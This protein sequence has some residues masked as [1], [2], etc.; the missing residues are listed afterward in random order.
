MAVWLFIPGLETPFVFDDWQ[1]LVHSEWI[2]GQVSW[3]N[4]YRPLRNLSYAF[5]LLFGEMAPFTFHV[6][7]L[8]YHTLN[9]VLLAGVTRL[10]LKPGSGSG[11]MA[12]AG[13]CIFFALHPVQIES[14]VYISGR[15]D[16]LFAFFYLGGM[17][18]FLTAYRSRRFGLA[19]GGLLVFTFLSSMSKEAGITLP[20][21]AW[22][23]KAFAGDGPVSPDRHPP[24]FKWKFRGVTVAALAAFLLLA[25]YTV[26][27]AWP[28][29]NSKLMGNDLLLH[30]ENCSVFLFR[31]IYMALWPAGL[32]VDHSEHSFDIIVQ[33]WDPLGVSALLGVTLASL[34]A[35]GTR[36]G[37]LKGRLS[38]N[39]GFMLA[40]KGWLW[41]II[42]ILPMSNLIPH[43]ERFAVHY[44]Y[45]PLPGI[46]MMIWGLLQGVLG[47]VGNG[48][49][50]K[51][52][53]PGQ[54]LGGFLILVITISL[55]IKTRGEMKWWQDEI[56][57]WN[58][59][60]DINPRCARALTN[61][62]MTLLKYNRQAEASDVFNRALE[63]RSSPYTHIGLAAVAL[64][65]ND[66]DA[67]KNRL[68]FVPKTYY[69]LRR[70]SLFMEGL[71]ALAEN[72]EA[73]AATAADLLVRKW[74]N[75]DAGYYIQAKL[76]E[77][78]GNHDKAI[79]LL[80]DSLQLPGPHA[81]NTLALIR[82]L[83]RAGRMEAARSALEQ[84]FESGL[85]KADDPNRLN[86]LAYTLDKLGDKP[87]AE[88]LWH[89][90]L[91]S[92]PAC[93]MAALNLS[94]ALLKKRDYG[95]TIALEQEVD[96]SNDGNRQL[97]SRFL[98]NVGVAYIHLEK[99]D[100]A[101]AVM[102]RALGLW[103]EN[104]SVRVNLKKLNAMR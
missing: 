41:F 54:L 25:A 24:R 59:T 32:A 49:F 66:F 1:V 68:R 16:L 82:A 97:A 60:V 61:F 84:G 36:W 50:R 88:A 11:W 62:G 99:T 38:D 15:R 20:F 89:Q 19:W 21:A 40:I 75:D 34:T 98:N 92:D 71:I 74:P 48:I 58:H 29:L 42:T 70:H 45:L 43:V 9:I 63:V 26:T 46:F 17:L 104:E 44:L 39:P 95:R 3:I 100:R 102:E 33:Y 37:V 57:F 13:T 56:S 96:L 77:A 51:N 86:D 72:N 8:V 4:S 55:C 85:W 10:I 47:G 87:R 6:S 52:S 90:S 101:A 27:M 93:L 81:R 22:V 2:S 69:P 64:D 73:D 12:W 14:V 7:N 18:L 53:K 23:F 5:D 78:K 31:Y 67:A 28:V 103:P 35:F 80:T 79:S 94:S 91:K 65:Q 76:A 83:T 30:L